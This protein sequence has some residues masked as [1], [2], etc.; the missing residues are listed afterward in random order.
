VVA[1]CDDVIASTIAKYGGHAMQ[2]A[3]T[4][5]AATERVAEA[6]Q[7]IKCTHVVNLQGDEILVLPEDLRKLVEA[8]TANPAVRAW[9]AI[10]PVETAE[11]LK[12]RSIVKCVVSRSNRIMFCTRDFTA[13]PFSHDGFEPAQKILGILGFEQTF[14]KNYPVLTRT[15]L[16]MYESIDQSRIIE[17]DIDLYG[18]RFTRGYPGINEP[19]EVPLVV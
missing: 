18:V 16:E 2:T 19:R 11:E 17:H 12:D 3:K 14:L 1:T 9:N 4:H 13:L 7:K 10:A 5:V 8:M 6:A 15:P